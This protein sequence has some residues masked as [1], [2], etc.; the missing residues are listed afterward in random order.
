VPYVPDALAAHT[1]SWCG[2]FDGTCTGQVWWSALQLVQ[3]C[4][5]L[6]RYAFCSTRHV[7]YHLWAHEPAMAEAV[8]AMLERRGGPDGPA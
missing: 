5:Q 2:R 1:T 7:D 6:R 8:G 3:E 4:A